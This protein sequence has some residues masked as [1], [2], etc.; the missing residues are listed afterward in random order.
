MGL[1]RRNLES[2][3]VGYYFFD[4]FVFALEEAGCGSFV[5]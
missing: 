3:H 2:W 5:W 4:V 1:R